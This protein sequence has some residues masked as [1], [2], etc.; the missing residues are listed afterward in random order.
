MGD[1]YGKPPK[2]VVDQG[3]AAFKNRK[4]YVTKGRAKNQI[5]ISS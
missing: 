4:Y 5:P 1:N 3:R 2:S